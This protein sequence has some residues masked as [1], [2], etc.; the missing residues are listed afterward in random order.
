[1]IDPESQAFIDWTMDSFTDDQVYQRFVTEAIDRAKLFYDQ[2]KTV[3]LTRLKAKMEKGA[4]EHGAPRLPP[5]VTRLE[6]EN[7]Y[8]DLLGWLLVA[9]WNA[10]AKPA[11]SIDKE[12]HES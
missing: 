2:P 3:I 7:E 4:E 6:L 11:G 5:S 12:S 1:M 8:L 9:K 10:R